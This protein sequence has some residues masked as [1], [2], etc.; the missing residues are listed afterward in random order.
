MQILTNHD[1]FAV[2]TT[3]ADELHSLLLNEFRDMY[4]TD[5][6]AIW[7]AEIQADTGIQLPPPPTVGDLDPGLIGGNPY[8]FC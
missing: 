2:P 6:L 5:W 7:Q 8:L 3:H 4:R 1:C